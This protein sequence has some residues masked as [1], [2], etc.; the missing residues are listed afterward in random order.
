MAKISVRQ[1]IVP[2]TGTIQTFIENPPFLDSYERETT[3]SGVVLV[4]G[5]FSAPYGSYWWE[6]D[7]PL[8]YYGLL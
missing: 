8:G 2:E 5:V 4:L 7:Y 1:S 3:P 6:I